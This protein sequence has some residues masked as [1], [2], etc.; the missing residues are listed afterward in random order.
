M[1][2]NVPLVDFD[3]APHKVLKQK[4]NALKRR[5]ALLLKKKLDENRNLGKIEPGF[6]EKKIT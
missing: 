2:Y 1:K 4:Y 3:S 6:L 5:C